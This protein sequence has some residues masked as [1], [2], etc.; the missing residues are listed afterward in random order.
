MCVYFKK[1]NNMKH[2]TKIFFLLFFFVSCRQ[3]IDIDEYLA[4]QEQFGMKMK[5][6]ASEKDDGILLHW[7]FSKNG[8]EVK[9]F[10]PIKIFRREKIEN[11]L[12]GTV[13]F[14]LLYKSSSDPKNNTYEWI[15]T[16]V[17]HSKAYYYTMLLEA[18]K[19]GNEL[20][21]TQPYLKAFP[22]VLSGDDNPC[23]RIECSG[24]TAD[25]C[26][27]KKPLKEKCGG[28]CGT[29]TYQCTRSSTATFC[30]DTLK[31]KPK[32]S[33]SCGKCNTG[34]Y[35]CNDDNTDIV[36][37]DPLSE[38]H[39][40]GE[41]CGVCNSGKYICNDDKNK[42]FCDDP[43]EG[44]QPIG[45]PC[46]K[47]NT[48]SFE[49]T[50][51]S[52]ATHCIDPL[53]NAPSVGK[54]CGGKCNTASYQCNE[55][56]RSMICIDPLSS[57]PEIGNTC[58]SSF[59][60]GKYQCTDN[61]KNITCL[62]FCG[63]QI[64]NKD[65]ECDTNDFG[66]KN[67]VDFGYDKGSLTC[68]NSCITEFSKCEYLVPLFSK[69]FGDLY[70]QISDRITTDASGN[71]FNMGHFQGSV[72]F[73]GGVLT[74]A[75][76]NDIFIAKFDG[77]GNHI[78][79]KR[80]GDSYNEYG[81][82]ISTDVS[83][84]VFITGHFQGSVD[85]GGGVLTSASSADIFIVK[86]DPNG[87]HIF[88]KR[89]DDSSSENAYA[90]GITTD[91]SDNILITGYFTSS[92][93][94]GGGVLN[95]IGYRMFV[96]KFDS[97]GNHIFSKS[98]G[99][100]SSLAESISIDLA[101]NILIGGSFKNSIDFGGG[102]LTSAG[103]K[104]IFIA[105]FDSSG[106][107]IFSKRFGDCCN[108]Q[109]IKSITADSSNNILIGG[110]FL[111]SIDFGGGALTSTGGSDI[112]IAKFD[113]QGNYLFSKRFGDR[114]S[115]MTNIVTVDANDN[116]LIS[117][118]ISGTVNFGTGL[119]KGPND[120]DRY[121]PYL[122]KFDANGNPVFSKGFN[123]TNNTLLFGGMTTDYFGNIVITGGFSGLVDFGGGILTS[124]GDSDIFLVKFSK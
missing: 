3:S 10:Y 29:A 76:E 91:S 124:A 113:K 32:V 46:G 92:I 38:E 82:G 93:D 41:S 51:S 24:K 44:N 62:P 112:Y 40:I 35:E 74:S 64:K 107:H 43:L 72:D 60:T 69:R 56:D 102:V 55:N 15:D 12:K 53:K 9:K 37:I 30:L 123:D 48:G 49:C 103:G 84:N 67:C 118:S 108:D 90:F 22:I 63:D 31:T 100:S 94:F 14:S 39:N 8:K 70:Y 88:S 111:G 86:F 109:Q 21:I 20:T 45:T 18:A 2:Q 110:F 121:S 26:I 28:K 50:K 80:F 96:V 120:L 57:Q 47:C 83:G 87:N 65:E 85:F 71:V 17:D 104:D 7:D 89:F 66:G 116:I 105:K 42:T 106:N 27:N 98:F 13:T 77:Q 6:F 4:S 101:D 16:T 5:L 73:G 52:T 1:G 11:E 117:G 58:V 36:C 34:I 61:N 115:Q 79:S 59:G 99:S 122:V 23:T 95:A 114:Y 119:I 68:T 54:N 81:T 78:W 19:T 97:S 75:G 25:S 33:S